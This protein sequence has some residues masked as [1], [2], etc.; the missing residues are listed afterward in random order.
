[1]KDNDAEKDRLLFSQLVI[2]FYDSAW[3]SLGKVMSTA[4]GKVERNLDIAR[5]S[6]DILDML[7]R[8]TA[9]NLEDDEQNF[10]DHAL[11]QL[12]MN[13]VEEMKVESREQ[14][15]TAAPESSEDTTQTGE[16]AEAAEKDGAAET[17]K[18]SKPKAP[19][20]KAKTKTKTNTKTKK[21][22]KRKSPP[23]KKKT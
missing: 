10:I 23:K 22:T 9:G 19:K 18:V 21:P 11:Y 4:T 13:Y 7:K 16:P 15:E 17:E 3:Q 20:P 12:K 1:M 5:N 2:T 14:T 8:R 6:I